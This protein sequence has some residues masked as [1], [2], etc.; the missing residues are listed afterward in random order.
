MGNGALTGVVFWL[1]APTAVAT[2]ALVFR[3]QSMVRATLLLLASFL[4]VAGILLA[5]DAAFLGAITVLMMTGEMIIM[6]VFMVMFM[7]D[8]GGRTGMDMSHQRGWSKTV[9]LGTFA[10][11]ATG[12]LT[13]D[14]PQRRGPPVADPTE[15][16]GQALFGAKML[17][18]MTLGVALF[19]VMIGAVA[20]ATQRGRYDR[21]GDDLDAPRALDPVPGGVGR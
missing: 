6:A 16:L 15:Q 9:A 17:V 7:Y 12:V 3:V 20:L 14:W 5:L 11:L 2:G 4:C 18:M 1:L 21:F 8:P 10:V 19:A 13:A